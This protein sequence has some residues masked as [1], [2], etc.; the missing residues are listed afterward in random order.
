MELRHFLYF[1]AVAEELHF[2]RAA[3]RLQ[4]TQP[5]LSKQIQQFEEEIGV[6]LFK[7]NKRHVELTTAGQLFLP[8]A[9]EI[10]AQVNQAVDTAQRADRGEFGRL[11]IGFVGSATYDILPQIIREYRRKFPHV[12][13]RLHELS[14][15]DQVSALIG[16]RIDV[17]LLHPP[18]SS[19]FI[20]TI[21][22]KRG[23]AALS[24][25]KNHPLAKKEHIYIEDLQDIPFIL[26]SRDIWPG[27]YD[28]FLSLFQS[29][30]FTPSIVQEAT[31]YQMVVGLVSAGIGIGV[32]PASAEKLFNLEVVYRQIDNYPLTAVLSLAYLK[33]NTNPALKQF[34]SLTKRIRI[35]E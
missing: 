15:P 28:E 20:E 26:V 6:P 2:G 25:P 13:I 31:E 18:V 23:F 32:V 11:V 17:G 30:G 7:R 29:V 24:L 4:M 22:I 16:E 35:D 34:V 27:L 9:R 8:E 33:K 3:A 12:S 10:I 5:P 1:I 21:P 14:T 19:S